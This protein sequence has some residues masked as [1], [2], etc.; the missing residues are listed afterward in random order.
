[1]NTEIES[2]PS[3]ATDPSREPE[4][5]QAIFVGL[6]PLELL[7]DGLVIWILNL[8]IGLEWAF[9]AS[10]LYPEFGTEPV[11]LALYAVAAVVLVMTLGTLAVERYWKGLLDVPRRLPASPLP[12]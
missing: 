6:V 10:C 8:A 9:L 3:N 4:T 11:I 12:Y 1:M 7:L 5:G 2:T